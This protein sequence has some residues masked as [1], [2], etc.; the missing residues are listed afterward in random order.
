MPFALQ[1][2]AVVRLLGVAKAIGIAVVYLG[3]AGF[4]EAMGNTSQLPALAGGL[5]A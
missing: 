2:A 3:G 5:V 1:V 4:F